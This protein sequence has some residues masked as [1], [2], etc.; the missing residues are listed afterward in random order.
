[1]VTLYLEVFN[2]LHLEEQVKIEEKL[3]E[4]FK[5]LDFTYDPHFDV[6]QYIKSDII[7]KTV[8]K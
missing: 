7:R 8:T 1:M 2:V 6:F 5:K 4:H 3:K